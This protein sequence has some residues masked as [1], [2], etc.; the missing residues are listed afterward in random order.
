MTNVAYAGL[1]DSFVTHLFI[2]VLFA[3]LNKFTD[4][5]TFCTTQPSFLFNSHLYLTR[6]SVLVST[7]SS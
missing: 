5:W 3:F 2:F 4:S 1:C 7:S 6:V